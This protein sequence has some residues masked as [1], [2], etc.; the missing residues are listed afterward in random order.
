MFPSQMDQTDLGMPSKEYYLHR[1]QPP[2]QA[3]LRYMREVV[4]LLGAQGPE[5]D[6]Q[7]RDMLDFETK[8][9]NVGE[10]MCM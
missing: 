4:R 10:N 3:Y 5:V 1:N 2:V 6:R 7:L 9:A 8:I